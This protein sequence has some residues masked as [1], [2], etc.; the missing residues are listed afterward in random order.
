MS[1]GRNLQ[2]ATAELMWD[3]SEPPPPLK[4]EKKKK[5]ASSLTDSRGPCCSSRRQETDTVSQRWWCTW[6]L[7]LGLHVT[8]GPFNLIVWCVPVA[9]QHNSPALVNGSPPAATTNEQFTY[10]WPVASQRHSINQSISQSHIDRSGCRLSPFAM[11]P[12]CRRACNASRLPL[13]ALWRRLLATSHLPCVSLGVSP[14]HRLLQTVD[15]QRRWNRNA[16]F[17]YYV[18]E[19]LCVSQLVRRRALTHPRG[20]RGRSRCWRVA[21]S[22]G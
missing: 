21:V 6:Q 12:S 20:G 1:R 16:F 3:R 13:L 10:V 5:K 4:K 15:C 14:S 11:S 18:E 22:R 17:L 8:L 7:V 9:G 2:R 19:K